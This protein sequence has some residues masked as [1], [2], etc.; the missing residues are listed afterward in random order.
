MRRDPALSH[1][2]PTSASSQVTPEGG[3]HNM[4][5]RKGPRGVPFHGKVE[6]SQ[7]VCVGVSLCRWSAR[8]SC[9]VPLVL[10]T[11]AQGCGVNP[12]PSGRAGPWPVGFGEPV[13]FLCCNIK[14][15]LPTGYSFCVA[16]LS[17]IVPGDSQRRLAPQPLS[18]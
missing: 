7:Q 9:P 11:V 1:C 6:L 4:L 12:G 13:S 2:S 10:R 8:H 18:L 3:A 16:V 15:T 17:A 14:C 5:L